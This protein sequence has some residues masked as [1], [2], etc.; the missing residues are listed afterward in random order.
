M[1]LVGDYD[2]VVVVGA[3]T[4]NR[5][6]TSGFASFKSLSP[7]LCRPYDE[8]RCG[9]NLGEAAGAIALICEHRRRCSF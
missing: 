3:D 9:L 2:M 5:F 8:S 4:Q 7:E 6:I 1:L